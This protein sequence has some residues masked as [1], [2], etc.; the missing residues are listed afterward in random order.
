[1]QTWIRQVFLSAANRWPSIVSSVSS[2]GS[3]EMLSAARHAALTVAAGTG[4]L[5][6]KSLVIP[7][8]VRDLQRDL[9]AEGTCYE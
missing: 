1:M 6:S 4:Y 5:R 2:C 8:D 9:P 7:A 3:A